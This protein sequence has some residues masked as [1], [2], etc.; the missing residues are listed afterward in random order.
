MVRSWVEK[1]VVDDGFMSG[2]DSVESTFASAEVHGS[3]VRDGEGCRNRG[4]ECPV[5]HEPFTVDAN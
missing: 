5:H 3:D 1:V 2:D 4:E